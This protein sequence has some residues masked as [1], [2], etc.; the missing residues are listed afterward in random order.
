MY[1]CK[2]VEISVSRYLLVTKA[3]PATWTHVA[4]E[5]TDETPNT[6]TLRILKLAEKPEDAQATTVDTGDKQDA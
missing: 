5:K 1:V 4:V 6:V 2:I 3:L